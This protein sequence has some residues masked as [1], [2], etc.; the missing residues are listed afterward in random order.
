MNES[1]PIVKD[2]H[3]ER[4]V[5]TLWRTTFLKIV[6]AFRQGDYSLNGIPGVKPTSLKDAERMRGNVD[7]YGAHLS[8]LPDATWETSVCRW[9]G[10]HWDILVDLFTEEEGASDLVLFS[11]V[12]EKNGSYEFE[13]DSMHVP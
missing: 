2:E 8:N 12:Y 7:S 3:E 11:K 1:V 10:T 4:Q 13:V 5:P 6:E 9:M